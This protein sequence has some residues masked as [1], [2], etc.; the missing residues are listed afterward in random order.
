M[1]SI[2]QEPSYNTWKKKVTISSQAWAAHVWAV[3]RTEFHTGNHG[4]R[5]DARID[6]ESCLWSK[7]CLFLGAN[8]P[9]VINNETYKVS[10]NY[11]QFSLWAAK[12]A[13]LA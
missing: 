12:S 9:F 4:S 10:S 6:V 1:F 8:C 5:V 3:G 7:M 13:I 11:F 2:D